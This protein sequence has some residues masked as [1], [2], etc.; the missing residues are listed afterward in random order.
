VK[1]LSGPKELFAI[2]NPAKWATAD[3]KTAAKHYD[4]FFGPL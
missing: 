3:P 1:T 4:G 2:T